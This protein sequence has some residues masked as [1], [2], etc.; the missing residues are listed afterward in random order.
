MISTGTRRRRLA[1]VGAIAAVAGLLTACTVDD[2]GDDPQSPGTDAGEET[3]GA[4]RGPDGPIRVGVAAREILNDYNRDII[5][6]VTSVVEAGGGSVEVTDGGGD[7]TTHNDNIES[8]INS[9][10]DALVI[11]LGD[12]EQ[13]APVV[14]RAVERDI[15]VVTAG[16]G[17]LVEG[18]ITDVG[19]DEALMAEMLGRTLLGSIDYEGDVYAF[20]VP[21][22]PLLETRLR[23]LEAMV[24]DYPRVNVERVP[25]EHSPARVQSQMEAIL[26]AN[27]DEGSIAAVWTAY[28]QL[29]TGAVQAIQQAGRNEINVAAIDGDRATFPILFSEDSP[30]VATVVQDAVHIGELAGQ[31]A[32]D[33]LSGDPEVGPAA[34]TTAWVATRSNGIAAAEERY[35][36]EVWD[37]LQLDRDAVEARYPQTQEV[38]VMQ[39]VVPTA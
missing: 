16:V 34:F 38:V 24:E 1:A 18:A 15:P 10:I 32:I 22:A 9:D 19:G 20:W 33:A 30:F 27:P 4:Q 7:Q 11:Q 3:P 37:E 13:M 39:P 23:V 6:G 35:G 8:L 12:A 26:S 36:P 17:S 21:G 25:T 29:A 5:A 31:I 2:P 14:Q 28:D